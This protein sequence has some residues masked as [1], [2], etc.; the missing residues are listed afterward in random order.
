[1]DARTRSFSSPQRY[2]QTMKI[3][4]RLVFCLLIKKNT[5]LESCLKRRW[6]QLYSNQNC[7]YGIPGHNHCFGVYCPQYKVLSKRH[8]K[9]LCCYPSPR[10]GSKCGPGTSDLSRS[11]QSQTDPIGH[12]RQPSPGRRYPLAIHKPLQK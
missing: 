12:R 11:E 7:Y 4:E 8:Q 6:P 10:P 9:F 5:R 1:M 2:D 3:L